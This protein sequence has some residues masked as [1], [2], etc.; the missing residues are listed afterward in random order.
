[1]ETPACDIGD[2]ATQ[3]RL[4]EAQWHCATNEGWRHPPEPLDRAPPAALAPA[5]ALG[6]FG[7]VVDM[8]HWRA[9]RRPGR[10]SGRG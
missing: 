9:V 3:A 10:A 8:L 4:D 7:N 2:T 6:S 5:L 1:M